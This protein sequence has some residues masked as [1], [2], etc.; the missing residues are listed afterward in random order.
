MAT[1]ISLSI[2]GSLESG[3]NTNGAAIMERI[4]I[5]VSRDLIV[6]R[7]VS[8]DVFEML[9][10]SQALYFSR[11]DKFDDNLEGGINAKNFPYVSNE[12]KVLDVAISLCWPGTSSR[13]EQ[14]LVAMQKAHSEIDSET[15]QSLFGV[16]KKINGSAYL[17]NISSWLY[18]SCWTDLPYE[19]QAMWQLYGSSGS[20]CRHEI[21]CLDCEKTVGNSV[22]IETTIGAILDNLELKEGFNLSIQKVEYLDHRLTEF[23]GSDMISRPFFSKALHFS[24]ENEVRLM[25]WSDRQDIEFSYQYGKG[26]QN[27]EDGQ[28]LHIRNI[29]A[30]IGKIILSPLS[31]KMAKK[32]IDPYK[33]PCRSQLGLQ[34][35]LA[36]LALRDKVKAL[37]VRKN[38]DIEIVDSDLN[39]VSASD[40]YTYMDGVSN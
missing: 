16:Q 39:Q 28:V 26:T 36:N 31:L 5:G 38:I 32:I 29:E 20:N 30:F 6:R 1:R 3:R 7:Y 9:I 21:G 24:Y 2:S 17:R 23:S 37:C 14:E 13:S 22:C 8:F 11:F 33:D 15:F 40:C 10:N 34:D 4:S 19:C 18:A 27:K 25:L 12:P 35:S